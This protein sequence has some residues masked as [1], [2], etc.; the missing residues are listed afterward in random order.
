MDGTA[1]FVE[2]GTEDLIIPQI[3]E[4]RE[5]KGA[6]R[7]ARLVSR[8]YHHHVHDHDHDAEDENYHGLTVSRPEDWTTESSCQQQQQQQQQYDDSS[9]SATTQA[10]TGG[11]GEDHRLLKLASFYDTSE[12]SGGYTLLS[13]YFLS[14]NYILGVG[15]LGIPYAFAKAGFLLCLA[16]LLIVTVFSYLTVMW[17]AETGVR[18]EELIRQKKRGEQA[19]LINRHEGMEHNE[20]DMKSTRYEVIDLVD[21]FLGK[22][23]KWIYQIA[24]LALMYVGLVSNVVAVVVVIVVVVS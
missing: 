5:R 8:R 13:M 19:P 17:V 23:Q 6:P 21:F 7:L 10:R 9:S 15:I 24:L 3:T 20:L 18:Y 4:K 16:L 14:I 2:D 1:V 22:F 11:R 12:E